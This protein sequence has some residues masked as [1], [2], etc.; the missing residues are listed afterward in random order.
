MTQDRRDVV[1]RTL[2]VP[3][4]RRVVLR[5]L[6]GGGLV[7]GLGGIGQGRWAGAQEGTPAATPVG[8]TPAAGEV[9]LDYIIVVFLEN[10][11][12][13]N[14]YGLFPGANGL[15]APGAVIV[16][17]D[18]NG[19]PYQTLPPVLDDYPTVKPDPRFP[20]DMPNAPFRLDQYVPLD[21][22]TPD[23][24]HRFYQHILQLNGG[25]LDR[26]VAWSDAGGVD[27]GLPR[28]D[29]AAALPLRPAVHALRQFL[30]R[31]LRWLD[32][33][34]LLADLRRDAGLA[35][36]PGGEDRPTRL[37]RRAAS[38]SICRRTGT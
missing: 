23:V 35:E 24:I 34:P 5:R 26:Y 18:K 6:A 33:Q 37:R 1:A 7:A 16:Q 2:A 11:T 29:Q 28:H 17:T 38:W 9:P 25:K 21:Q 15:E 10:H 19:V 32:A 12:F 4:T 31:R 30:H 36:R 22:P 8:A 13:D 14:L 20:P 3:A 27:D